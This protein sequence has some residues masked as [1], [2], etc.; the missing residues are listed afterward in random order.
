MDSTPAAL[1]NLKDKLVAWNRDVFGHIQARKK[2]TVKRLAG[3]QKALANGVSNHL[4]Q[5]DKE[6]Q[7]DLCAILEQEELLWFQKSRELWLQS[8]DRNTKFFHM[9]IL[10]RR[11]RNWIESLSNSDGLLI[12]DPTQLELLAK[13]FFLEL[14]SLPDGEHTPVTSRGSFLALS[15]TVWDSLSQPFTNAEIS[16]AIKQMGGFKV[17]GIDGFQ[18][19]FF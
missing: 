1:G 6:L 3:I 17:P 5:L 9:S 13:S 19:M 4:F 7:S 16:K 10:M 11:K 14:Y 8:E 15:H 2:R 18:P 12:D